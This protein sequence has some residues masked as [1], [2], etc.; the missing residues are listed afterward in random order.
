MAA[1]DVDC[2]KDSNNSGRV[3]GLR[4]RRGR[5]HRSRDQK[6]LNS[7]DRHSSQKK[8]AEEGKV[9]RFGVVLFILLL[10]L[11]M[12]LALMFPF[13][14]LPSSFPFFSE[15]RHENIYPLRAYSDEELGA[16]A[17]RH[18]SDLYGINLQNIVTSPVSDE[19]NDH[20]LVRVE[21]SM[22]SSI[23]HQ[24]SAIVK[25]FAPGL[26]VPSHSRDLKEIMRSYRDPTLDYER[27]VA[28]MRALEG[29]NNLSPNLYMARDADGVIVVEDLKPSA[30]PL[31]AKLGVRAA[32]SDAEY[33][34]VEIG[35]MFPKLGE[36]FA[37]LHHG[38]VL[39]QFKDRHASTPKSWL[40]TVSGIQDK[41]LFED[42]WQRFDAIASAVLP[43]KTSSSS[44]SA[45]SDRDRITSSLRDPTFLALTHG[46]VC[47]DNIFASGKAGGPSNRDHPRLIDYSSAGLRHALSDVA[48]VALLFP[49]CWAAGDM[50]FSFITRFIESYRHR[51]DNPAFKSVHVYGREL[52]RLCAFHLVVVFSEYWDDA[53]AGKTCGH[54][55]CQKHITSRVSAF[56]RIVD[57]IAETNSRQNLLPG[58][59]SIVQR[60]KVALATKWFASSSSWPSLP[61]FPAFT[62]P[63]TI[64]M[65]RAAAA[66]EELQ[67]LRFVAESAAWAVDDSI[68][69][70]QVMWSDDFR[71]NDL[72]APTLIRGCPL[73]GDA[74]PMSLFCRDCPLAVKM[75]RKTSLSSPVFRAPLGSGY[76]F[77]SRLGDLFGSNA[78][79]GTQPFYV[80]QRIQLPEAFAQPL[81]C[82]EYGTCPRETIAALWSGS[83]GATAPLHF[84]PFHNVFFQFRGAKRFLLFHPSEHKNVYMHPRLHLRHRQA[85][86]N[87]NDLDIERF[88]RSEHL[89]GMRVDVRPGDILYIPPLWLHQVETLPEQVSSDASISMSMFTG[90]SALQQLERAYDVSLAIDEM[91]T[92]AEATAAAK[93]LIDSIVAGVPG[94]GAGAEFVKQLLD[95]RYSRVLFRDQWSP[96]LF[97]PTLDGGSREDFPFFHSG[98]FPPEIPDPHARM[99]V[100]EMASREDNCWIGRNAAR[101]EYCSGVPKALQDR[102]AAPMR[103]AADEIASVFLECKNEDAKRT[104]MHDFIEELAAAAV[105]DRNVYEFFRRCYFA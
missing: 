83:Q 3:G 26:Y 30:V 88:P 75:L 40:L 15:K 91:W 70:N 62:K 35:Y 80:N 20:R 50:P 41:E 64:K 46:D 90:P 81:F 39:K 44:S 28:A 61:P 48:S 95:E 49:T 47:A 89:R 67:R 86:V 63:A 57:Y 52:I 85:Q 18:F 54:V 103:K 2:N 9:L 82:P 84:D 17:Q 69:V 10:P 55:E 22:S 104:Y 97:T 43:G 45:A 6:R 24:P 36:T 25:Q 14:A 98:D 96:E 51:S 4:R 23:A 100:S 60:L 105:G 99:H 27:E 37:A 66:R 94:M 21:S 73:L 7:R 38:S 59:C 34:G 76:T 32:G 78:S 79:I 1:D 92:T 5:G 102:I 12:L 71:M 77:Q 33:A 65:V 13:E 19:G 16:F 87:L 101:D 53:S 74:S 58:F 31:L 11:G 56:L 29:Q 8:S 93:F 72:N 42:S 68:E